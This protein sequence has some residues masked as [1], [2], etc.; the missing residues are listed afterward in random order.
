MVKKSVLLTEQFEK[1]VVKNKFGYN[2]YAIIESFFLQK[3]YEKVFKNQNILYQQFKTKIV[4]LEPDT[5]LI[6]I[7]NCFFCCLLCLCKYVNF[8]IFFNPSLK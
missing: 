2:I 8:G 3:H 1:L 4:E 5:W 7:L 6:M